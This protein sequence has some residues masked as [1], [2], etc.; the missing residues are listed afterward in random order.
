[1]Y[2]L[3]APFSLLAAVGLCAIA[4]NKV[5]KGR[6]K[7][8]ARL[9]G[10]VRGGG[11]WHMAQRTLAYGVAGVG[12][13]TTLTAMATLHPYE[14]LYFNALT[15]TR[16]PGALG[17]RYALDYWRLA[18]RQSLEYLLARYP[19]D[20][21]RVWRGPQSLRILPQNDRERI[22]GLRNP[23]A[24]DFYL[25]GDAGENRLI[26][27]DLQDMSFYIHSRV[28]LL[29]ALEQPPIYSINAYGS[30]IAYIFAPNDAAAYRAAYDDVAANGTLLARS[31]F[32]LY[33]YDGALYYLSAN[34]APPMPNAPGM[35]VFLHIFPDHSADLPED[36]R[37]HGFENRDFRLDT[38]SAFF[39]GKCIH[40]QPLPDY[41]IA[42]IRT[43][44]NGRSGGEVIWRADIDLAA[45]AAVHALYDSAAAGD[46][47]QPVA[48][49]AFDVYL[50]G[51]RL[52]YLKEPCA[53]G[54]VDARF[55]LHIF[56]ADPADLPA[57]WR[58]FGF[59]NRDFWLA[60]H[61]ARAGD[62]CVAERELPGYA[63]ERIR[64]GQFVS[65]EGAIWR[66]E[67]AVGR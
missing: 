42:R 4:I 26:R 10:W 48:Q 67:F 32:D 16:T 46:Y 53:P 62:I 30:A 18:Q 38:Q 36:R 63:I 52:A 25:F 13:I 59:E 6:L 17:E 15:D 24:A 44:T 56:P 51:N 49:S 23:H 54:D 66:V 11:R 22:I 55:F 27:K 45:H 12:L 41:P 19:D 8:A 43:G 29:S 37:E 20:T 58:E 28:N 35:R 65:G 34:C 21:L 2:F 47:G 61:G 50:R 40:R 3:W 31:A 1:M 9:P 7:V 5:G 14:H 57:D 39:D 60:D 64:T 33:A